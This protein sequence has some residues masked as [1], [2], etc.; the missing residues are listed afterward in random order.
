MR[1]LQAARH[2]ESTWENKAERPV[3]FDTRVVLFGALG[4]VGC[5]A[6]GTWLVWYAVHLDRAASLEE[7]RGACARTMPDSAER[8][9]D[10][11]I[12]QRGGAR[13]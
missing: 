7:I 6:I 2:L 12:I 8:C 13:R 5:C 1:D 4:L 11:V 3:C 9:V 10:T